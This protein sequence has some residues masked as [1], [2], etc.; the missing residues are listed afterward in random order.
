MT[1]FYDYS[2]DEMRKE[3]KD[4]SGL[5]EDYGFK[6]VVM[7]S[8]LD[9]NPSFLEEL[10]DLREKY[11]DLDHEVYAQFEPDDEIDNEYCFIPEIAAFLE[12]VVLTQEEL[13]KVNYLCFD[14]GNK[15]YSYIYRDW[16]G[17]DET[18]D[19]KSIKGFEKLRNL[20]EVEY[21]SLCYEDVLEPM[22]EAGISIS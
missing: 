10:K 1:T 17:E 15:I 21:I 8:L 7:D 6:L 9:K 11:D 4:K 20:K 18:F 13:D 3:R 14:A 16:D 12:N 2:Y 5:F 19:V 22:K